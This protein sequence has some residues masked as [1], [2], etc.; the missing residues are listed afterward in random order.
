[1]VCAR[2]VIRWD[3]FVDGSRFAVR[4]DTPVRDIVTGHAGRR[5]R[6][7]LVDLIHD[8]VAGDKPSE[9]WWMRQH[10]VRCELIHRESSWLQ[11]LATQRWCMA[12]TCMQVSL[13]AGRLVRNLHCQL[14]TDVP[15]GSRPSVLGTAELPVNETSRNRNNLM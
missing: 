4:A 7:Q 12:S 10:G 14:N 6:R 3:D 2:V 15:C 8:D 5:E 9:L 11:S 13:R 1:M